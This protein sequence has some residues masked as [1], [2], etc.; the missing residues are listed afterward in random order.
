MNRLAALILSLPKGLDELSEREGR[1]VVS[2]LRRV[3][4]YLWDSP[5]LS[6]WIER[7]ADRIEATL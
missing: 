1:F 5:G 6:A 7:L 2:Q 4:A 3:A